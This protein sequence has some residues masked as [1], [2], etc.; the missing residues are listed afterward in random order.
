MRQ[1]TLSIQFHP[2]RDLLV[3][4]QRRQFGAVTLIEGCTGDGD[5]VITE[6]FATGRIAAHIAR[7]FTCRHRRFFGE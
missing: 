3:T 1:L 2:Q 5:E 6:R 7:G 4:L